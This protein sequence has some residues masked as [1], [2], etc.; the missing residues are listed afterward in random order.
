MNLES[1][2]RRAEFPTRA[3]VDRVRGALAIGALSI[4]VACSPENP[5]LSNGSATW[6]TQGTARQILSFGKTVR[7]GS[8]DPQAAPEEHPCLI[9]FAHD[10]WLDTTE[11]T[12]LEYQILTSR[13][14]APIAS[15]DPDNPVVDVTWFDAI[16]FC[17]AR[18]KRDHLDTVYEYSAVSADSTGSVW[19]LDALT[20]HLDRNGWRLP[21]EA[22]WEFAARAGSKTAYAWGDLADSAKASEYAWFQ[23]N[24]G[25]SLHEGARLKPNAWGFYDMGGNAMEWVQD[26]KGPFPREMVTDY[27]GPDVPPDIPEAPLKGGA[28][29]YGLEHLRPSSRSATYPAYRA[30]KSEY[31]GFRCARGGFTATYTNGSGQALQVPPVSILRTDVARVLGAR[32]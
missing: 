20:S 27:V 22:E 32:T 18:S 4:V 12:Q 21:S 10:F 9:R 2:H 31:V 8:L 7:V 13:N 28:Y 15:R 16:L 25:Y 19:G 3:R 29:T 17:N 1:D 23:K 11:V 5:T 30:A 24:A 6:S 14:P 26:W